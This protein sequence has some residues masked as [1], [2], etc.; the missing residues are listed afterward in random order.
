MKT[1]LTEL[2]KQRL[3]NYLNTNGCNKTYRSRRTGKV[4]IN[5]HYQEDLDNFIEM[6]IKESPAQSQR[7]IS[8]YKWLNSPASDKFVEDF[9][10]KTASC[11]DIAKLKPINQLD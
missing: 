8:N 1:V 9:Q 2:Q 5:K 11:R 7:L 10:N 6:L 4:T 3:A